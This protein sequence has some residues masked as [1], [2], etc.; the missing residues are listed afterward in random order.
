MNEN[1]T[2]F[3]EFS[4]N[5]GVKQGGI[6]SSYLFNIFI[7]DLITEVIDKNLGALFNNIN[8]SIIVYADDILL[9]SPVGRHLQIMLDICSQYSRDWLIKFNPLK[10]TV[11]TFGKPIAQLQTFK[12]SNLELNQT[13]EIQYLGV[14]IN[15]DLD[16]DAVAKKKFRKVE[17]CI[18]SLSYLG[19]TPR[20]VNPD[21]KSFIYKTYCLSQFTYGLE[22]PT[23]TQD[24]IKYLDVAQNNM[25]RQF[26]G[27]ER[28]C[29]MSEIRKI[30]KIMDINTLY[31]KSKLSF[32]STIKHNEL[33]LGI[34]NYLC[35][36]LNNINIKT[37][38]FEKDIV[39]LEKYL[40]DNFENMDVGLMFADPDNLKFIFKESFKYEEDGFTDS[41][42]YLLSKFKSNRHKILLN[43]LI[44]PEYKQ[45]YFDLM[46]AIIDS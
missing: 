17:K 29:H 18:F 21:L 39:R 2:P 16:F 20:G 40:Q 30:L 7:N 32:I 42:T 25:I 41:I 3:L 38:S 23:L 12:L 33:S 15:K 36:N 45:Q 6:L 4:I 35:E 24:T 22:T 26:I 5:C 31:L 11:I 19:L 1:N 44:R 37:K 46:H 34:F 8:M 27:L 9:I 14:E 10:S 28:N 43:N 13:N